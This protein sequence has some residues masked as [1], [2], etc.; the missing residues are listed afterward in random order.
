MVTSQEHED[1][2]DTRVEIEATIFIE[3]LASDSNNASNV[4]ICNSLDLSANGLQ[5]VVDDEMPAGSIFR[6]CIDLKDADPIFLVAGVKWQRPDPETEGF[7]IGFSRFESN[8]TDIERWKAL[9]SDMLDV[10]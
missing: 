7:R 10:G 1:R 6:L 4:L 3:I 2:V 5:V 9:V 8:D